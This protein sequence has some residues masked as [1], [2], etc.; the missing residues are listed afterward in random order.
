MAKGTAMS[1]DREADREAG[2]EGAM[3]AL[4]EIGNAYFQYLE[5]TDGTDIPADVAGVHG[6]AQELASKIG[7]S[8]AW[9][10]RVLGDIAIADHRGELADTVGDKSFPGMPFSVTLVAGLPADAPPATTP[11]AW[12]RGLQPDGAWSFD[13]PFFG[14]G[15]CIL[16][17]DGRVEFFET[18]EGALINYQT[19]EPTSDI[20]KAVP[21]GAKILEYEMPEEVIGV[22]DFE[23]PEGVLEEIQ[24]E[25]ENV[26]APDLKT[27]SE[28]ELSTEP[29]GLPQ[30]EPVEEEVEP[31]PVSPV[32]SE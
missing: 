2:R 15:G 27:P 23:L 11:L 29:I 10:Y 12:T 5:A 21:P 26:P 1:S 6:W 30:L 28:R 20:T 31:V 18:V 13:S 9:A 4:K 7:F 14:E 22:P 8:K 32:S 25:F 3:Y 24:L 19:K 16:F 17:R